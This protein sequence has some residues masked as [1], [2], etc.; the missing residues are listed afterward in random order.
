MRAY[1]VNRENYPQITQ[2]E[3]AISNEG[4]VRGIARSA[5]PPRSRV[6]AATPFPRRRLI[7]PGPKWDRRIPNPEMGLDRRRDRVRWSRRGQ[8]VAGVLP[9]AD[10]T[11]Y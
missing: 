4:R 10:R 5:D 7:Y 8:C 1:A 11:L 3:S 2:I 9:T 6:I